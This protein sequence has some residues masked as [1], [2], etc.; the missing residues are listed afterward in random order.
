MLKLLNNYGINTYD[1][2]KELLDS[3]TDKSE[4]AVK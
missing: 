4:N 1:K 3:E 2:L